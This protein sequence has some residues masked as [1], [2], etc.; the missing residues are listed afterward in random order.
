VIN[1]LAMVCALLLTLAF[2]PAQVRNSEPRQ[3]SSLTLAQLSKM[4]FQQA[5]ANGIP[6]EVAEKINPNHIFSA[7]VLARVPSGS[8]YLE[9]AENYSLGELYSKTQLRGAVIALSMQQSE[10][11]RSEATK[12]PAAIYACAPLCGVKFNY[13]E[14]RVVVASAFAGSGALA[15]TACGFVPS[16]PLQAGCKVAFA[17]YYASTGAFVATYLVGHPDRCLLWTPYVPFFPF[18]YVKC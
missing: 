15:Q 11:P 13:V 1:G 2:N 17:V 14:T 5:F 4:T 12:R 10:A 7:G 3:E 18:N 6:D 16:L 9:I 8:S